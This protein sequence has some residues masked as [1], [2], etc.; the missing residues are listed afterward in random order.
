MLEDSHPQIASANSRRICEWHSFSS[1]FGFL[2]EIYTYIYACKISIWSWPSGYI[3]YFL[4][5]CVWLSEGCICWRKISFMCSSSTERYD[6][7]QKLSSH[8]HA[9]F[10][11]T[12]LWLLMFLCFYDKKSMLLL[13]AINKACELSTP[14]SQDLI[15]R[16]RKTKTS[17]QAN[18]WTTTKKSRDSNLYIYTFLFL[19]FFFLLSFPL[20]SIFPNS[21]FKIFE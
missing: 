4:F 3:F 8:L 2:N 18:K 13:S 7:K 14:Q 6:F 1:H 5:A 21:G 16:K 10:H 19:L 20:Y 9:I 15:K 12:A 11:R 17:K